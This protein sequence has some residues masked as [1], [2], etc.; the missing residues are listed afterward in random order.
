[1]ARSPIRAG[2]IPARHLEESAG[3]A[4]DR[5]RRA[6]RDPQYAAMGRWRSADPERVSRPQSR[7][8]SCRRRLRQ[9][10]RTGR[11]D[12]LASPTQ[13]N[14]ELN[15]A[16]RCGC[17]VVQMEER[18]SIMVPGAASVR[19]ARRRRSWSRCSTNGQGGATPR[20]GVVHHLLGQS[21]PAAHLPASELIADLG[22]AAKGRRG[23]AHLRDLLVG[24]PAES[25]GGSQGDHVQEGGDRRDRSHTLQSSARAVA[26]LTARASRNPNRGA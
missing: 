21:V 6:W 16:G 2:H 9:H 19:Q 4:T 24:R 17:P 3:A 14:A 18:R 8:L 13:L 20:R 5:G 22:G 25:R 10:T 23:G 15:G 1:M 11:N 26:A 12:Q 7:C